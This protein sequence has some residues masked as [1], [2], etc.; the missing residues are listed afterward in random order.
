MPFVILKKYFSIYWKLEFLIENAFRYDPMYLY[1]A[2]L[3]EISR[4]PT[5]FKLRM[6]PHCYS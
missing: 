2:I 6:I 3:I 4:Y 1:V 5:F